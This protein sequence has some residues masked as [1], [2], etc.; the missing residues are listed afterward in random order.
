[1]LSEN[2]QDVTEILQTVILVYLVYAV[3]KKKS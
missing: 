3:N 1:M 2:I